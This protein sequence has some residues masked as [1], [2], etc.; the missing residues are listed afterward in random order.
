VQHV[1]EPTTFAVGTDDIDVFQFAGAGSVTAG[2]NISVTGSQVAVV[3]NPTF[4]GLVT[5]SASGVA[6][7][8]GTQTK[9]GV[10]SITTISQKTDS[11][12]LSNLNERDTIVE[13][14]KGSATTLTIP[15]DGT[16]NYPVGTT[17]DIIQT[18]SGQVTIA[19]AGGVTVNATPGLKLRTQWSSA[20]LLKRASN[21]W[22]VFG[23]L[24]A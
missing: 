24:T 2:T 1:D 19:G 20:T 6:F 8:D 10:P 16:I 9:V 15:A 22:L 21:T 12:T 13:I 18:G 23:D 4:S 5:A 7:S 3:A 14:S 11:Y 17:I